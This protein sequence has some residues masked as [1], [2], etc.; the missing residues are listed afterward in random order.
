MVIFIKQPVWLWVFHAWVM[1][2]LAFATHHY[3]HCLTAVSIALPREYLPTKN[4]LE[5]TFERIHGMLA[6]VSWVVSLDV[7]ISSSIRFP[8]NGMISSSVILSRRKSET[9]VV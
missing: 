3:S 9:V 1:H 5:S 8:A 7:M 6:F 4:Y 2:M